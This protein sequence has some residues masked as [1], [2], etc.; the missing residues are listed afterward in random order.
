[1]Y[2]IDYDGHTFQC[3]FC[4]DIDAISMFIANMPSDCKGGYIEK[5]GMVIVKY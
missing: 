3:V 4:D 5:D 2:T 1:M